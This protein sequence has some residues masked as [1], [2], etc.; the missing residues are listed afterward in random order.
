MAARDVI[1]DRIRAALGSAPAVIE[2]HRTYRAAGGTE[3]SPPR[4]PICGPAGGSAHRL[5]GDGPPVQRRRPRH[6]RRELCAVSSRLAVPSGAPAA[7]LSSYPGEIV[8]DGDPQPLTVAD[9][10]VPG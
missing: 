7:W 3:E 10:D 9:L 5:P 1:M 6:H 8:R 2:V 4:A